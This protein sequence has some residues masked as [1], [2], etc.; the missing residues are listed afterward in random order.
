MPPSISEDLNR[1]LKTISPALPRIGSHDP[2]SDE[3]AHHTSPELLEAGRM[4]GDLAEYLERRPEEFK[5]ASIFYA[6]CSA[7]SGLMP[8]VR[9][10]C[11]SALLKNK[12]DWDAAVPAKLKGVP[13]EVIGIASEL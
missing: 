8:A 9:A 12:K 13:P 4:L 3:A 6:D 1:L 2:G 5:S 11:Y 10:V 7:D